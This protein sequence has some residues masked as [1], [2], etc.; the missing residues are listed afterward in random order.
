MRAQKGQEKEKE[1]EGKVERSSGIERERREQI[2]CLTRLGSMRSSARTPRRP[3]PS[4]LPSFSLL[5]SSLRLLPS[6]LS[7]P[8]HR[9]SFCPASSSVLSF[10]LLT[11]MLMLLLATVV[12]AAN[13]PFPLRPPSH[14]RPPTP[15]RSTSSF[16]SSLFEKQRR[17]PSAQRTRR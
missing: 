9:L 13:P 15:R 10:V 11:L 5:F 1:K 16:A 8:F 6:Y 14:P 3:R 12:G 7:Y 17:W 4:F 2:P